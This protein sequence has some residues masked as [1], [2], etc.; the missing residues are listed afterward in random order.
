MKL[1]LPILL[2]A[3]LFAIPVYAE[4][5]AATYGRIPLTFE[6]NQGQLDG[7]VKF[8]SRGPRYGL[9]LTEDGA[10]L[11]LLGEKTATVQMRLVGG[12]PPSD[13]SGIDPAPGKV[14]Y[15][16]GDPK[17]WHG[18]IA[19]YS[20]VRYTAVYPGI[21][22]IYYGT[23]RQLEYDF[24][25]A[26][27]ARPDAIQLRFDGVQ[28]LVID[29]QGDLVLKTDAG[30]VRQPKPVI[31]QEIGGERKR[32]DGGYVLRGRSSVGFHLG[33]YDA[34]Q[35]LT[36]DPVL[37]YSTYFGGSGTGVD[38]AN[39]I[40][41]D[42]QGYA[43]ITGVTASDGILLA[44]PFQN[45][46]RGHTD[47]FVLKLDP[48]GTAVVYSTYIG[49]SNNDEGRGIA[50]DAAGNAY[51][52]GFTS[53][54]DFPTTADALQRTK[55]P[56]QEAF[57]LKLNP[58]GN[59]V[60]YATYLGGDGDDVGMGVAV[61]PAGGVYVTGLTGSTDFEV[62]GGYQNSFQG[63]A[64]DVFV[65][66]LTPA[67]T[68][69]YSTYIGGRGNDQPYS[70][71]VDG[72]GAAYVTG[73]TTSANVVVS[74]FTGEV[75]RFDRAF[76]VVNAFQG[77]FSGGSDDAFVLKLAPSGNSL[78]YS[79]YVG[80]NS[81]DIATRVAVNGAG[82]AC[83]TGY[84]NS[85]FFPGLNQLQFIL[86]GGY[87]AFITCMAADGRSALLSTFFGGE[88]NDSGTG[89]AFDPTGMLYVAGYTDSILLTTQN[90][91]QG[92]WN[93]QRDGWVLKYNL[94]DL[95]LMYSTFLGG[96]G[97]DAITGLSVDAAG[98]AYV[99]GLTTSTDLPVAFPVQS[100]NAGGQDA[101]IAKI[102]GSDVGA[103][104]Q[105]AI[106]SQGGF[107]QLTTSVSTNPVF[108][109][110]TADVFNGV[111]PTGVE[112]LSL[113]QNGVTVSEIGILAPELHSAG[114]VYVE[115]DTN[116]RSVLTLAN[117]SG[118]T[119]SVDFFF[120]DKDGNGSNFVSQQIGP[121]Q[122]FSA[123][124]SDPPFNQTSGTR[125]TNNYTSSI[126]LAAVAFRTTNNER[127]EF[128]L[129]NTPI[130]NF[131]DVASQPVTISHFADGI[132][133][134]YNLDESDPDNPQYVEDTLKRT[135][136]TTSVVLVNTTED[137]M[138][139]NVD[140]FDQSGQPLIVSLTEGD[141]AA[142]FGY[143]IPPRSFVKFDTTG[144]NE[145]ISVGTVRIVPQ[146][147]ATPAA[148]AILS[149]R[150]ADILVSQTYV[151]APAVPRSSRV[152]VEFQGDFYNGESGALRTAIAI[153]ND[154]PLNRPLTLQLDLST[155]DGTV[156]GLSAH[157]TLPPRGQ[158]A[159]FIDQFPEF[160][161]L[162][163]GFRGILNVRITNPSAA[164]T[165][166]QVSVIAMR[167]LF[168]ERTQ[169]LA[170]TTGPLI[171]TAGRPD[172]LIFPHIAEGGGYSTEFIMVGRATGQSAAG[173]LY[174]LNQTGGALNATRKP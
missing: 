155:M 149:E 153:A 13:I 84:T 33:R 40:V 117:A 49:G 77:D 151:E 26:A 41:V 121:Y 164:G 125:G 18:D 139:G 104:A 113:V 58:A 160:A 163:N 87:D 114:R 14:N 9:A 165:P 59:G 128:V 166:P 22:L 89:I 47:G 64:A 129:S 28:K 143:A 11:R 136:W 25:V 133:H 91:L 37:V 62:L 137:E 98:N 61:D 39:G 65:T 131:R 5:P 82:N 101:F 30:D 172:K 122:H 10:V 29:G 57:L 7:R 154:D 161:A 147:T 157:V 132:V 102:N 105:F 107:R 167:T 144:A 31:Y 90:A 16:S 127:S 116:T 50:I 6:A 124:V 94:P 68:V 106:S 169:F 36:I 99:A 51:V 71:A 146:G 95:T 54:T 44:N 142:S 80:G 35:P 88:S 24:T 56:N 135:Q 43:Y 97:I 3:L 38:Q 8:L 4:T 73:F 119:A 2:L 20:K 66:K 86:N 78:V 174:F 53:S 93:G 158:I 55:R 159:Q 48:T 52:T 79:T 46:N 63:G 76:P 141:P 70:I 92:N 130:A 72:A 170:A 150:L 23:Q 108:G 171:E 67:G 168:N 17:N 103:S 145:G 15:L 19:T 74:P 81:S 42:A 34:S 1:K 148:H 75:Q 100:A 120:T 112:L 109:Y 173:V 162:P 21:D 111:A 134:I 118:E 32:I 152:F 45:G 27:G 69:A 126:P 140:F 115:V 96:Q 138:R 123:F 12:V 60:T 110:S 156:T 85:D 83:I